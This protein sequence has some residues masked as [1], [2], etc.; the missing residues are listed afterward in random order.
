MRQEEIYV[1]E[2]RRAEGPFKFDDAGT[3]RRTEKPR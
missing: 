1:G 2:D 3:H